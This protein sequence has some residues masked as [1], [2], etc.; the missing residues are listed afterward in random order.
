SSTNPATSGTSVRL[1]P[2]ERQRLDNAAAALGL[3]PS[4]FAR[5]AVLAAIRSS[6]ADA[7]TV[8]S[9][10]IRARLL[11][12]WTLEVGHLTDEV[13]ALTAAPAGRLDAAALAAVLGSIAQVHA[14]VIRTWEEPR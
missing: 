5:E 9:R 4:R 10:A 11:A 8:D 7:A 13:R 3:G 14:A 12:R 1:T 2:A 6:A